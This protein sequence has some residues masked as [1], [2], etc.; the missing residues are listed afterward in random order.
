M[1]KTSAVTWKILLILVFFILV[2]LVIIVKTNAP[3]EHSFLTGGSR[4][5]EKSAESECHKLPLTRFEL[6]RRGWTFLHTMASNFPIRDAETEQSQLASIAQFLQHWG[7]IY[8]CSLCGN[9]FLEMIKRT[10]PPLSSRADFEIWL[11]EVCLSVIVSL[12]VS[13]ISET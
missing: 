6:G 13:H 11:C 3:V 9:H 5:V 8:P 2:F 7:A 10:P 1:K 12:F 4:S